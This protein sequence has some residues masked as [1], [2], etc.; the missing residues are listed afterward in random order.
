[1]ITSLDAHGPGLELLD[2]HGLLIVVILALLFSLVVTT[3]TPVIVVIGCH[4]TRKL[5]LLLLRGRLQTADLGDCAHVGIGCVKI[6]VEEAAEVS[7]LAELDNSAIVIVEL[8][9]LLDVA[10]RLQDLIDSLFDDAQV[11]HHVR[12][13]HS[14]GAQKLR[15]LLTVQ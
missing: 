3:R 2:A 12:L 7:V 1:L 11:G 9:R 5:M 10:V 4:H 8:L 15:I 14:L 13:S 6:I